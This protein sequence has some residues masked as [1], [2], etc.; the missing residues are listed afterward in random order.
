[1]TVVIHAHREIRPLWKA[2]ANGLRCQCP[3]CGEGKLFRAF[4]KIDESC[5]NC[6]E[7]LSHHKADDLPPYIAIVIVGHVLVG[8][9]MHVEMTMRVDPWVYLATMVPLAV[10][11]PVAM[12]PSIKGAVAAL[13]WANYMH[14]FDPAHRL[15]A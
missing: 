8:V 7:V 1:M 11:L 15:Q 5:P 10:I 6:G 12:L 4:L 14:G 13:Q 3:R 2:I 9:M